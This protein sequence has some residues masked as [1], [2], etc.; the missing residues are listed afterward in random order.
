MR[1][2]H[3]VDVYIKRTMT[4]AGVSKHFASVLL[5]ELGTNH[6]TGHK[7]LQQFLEDKEAEGQRKMS[8]ERLK[9]TYVSSI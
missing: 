6:E 3:D 7:Q 4:R 1:A 5:A 9:R 2:A 8:Q